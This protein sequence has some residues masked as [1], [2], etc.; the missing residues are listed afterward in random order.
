MDPTCIVLQVHLTIKH[1]LTPSCYYIFFY[2][3]NSLRKTFRH[4]FQY[5]RALSTLPTVDQRLS[6]VSLQGMVSRIRVLLGPDGFVLLSARRDT[7]PT[8]ARPRT[9]NGS[10]YGLGTTGKSGVVWL[11]AVS[12]SI[13]LELAVPTL[14]TPCFFSSLE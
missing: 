3:P 8:Q 5:Q 6:N 13:M 12:G 7:L 2:S 14:L 4:E 10:T 1:T 11:Y 9:P